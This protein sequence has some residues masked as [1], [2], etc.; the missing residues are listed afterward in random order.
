MS[1]HLT[2][3]SPQLQ[4]GSPELP[5]AEM[6][7]RDDSQ[8]AD[9][10]Q[11][12]EEMEVDSKAARLTNTTQ[13]CIFYDPGRVVLAF[14]RHKGACQQKISLKNLYVIA[15]V[16]GKTERNNPVC[17]NVGGQNVRKEKIEEG[18]WDPDVEEVKDRELQRSASPEFEPAA[19]PQGPEANVDCPICQ[20][21]FP[22][23]EIEIHAA[24][25]DGEVAVVD[26][27]RP[28]VNSFQSE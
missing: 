2:W 28:E 12:E 13:N 24:Y 7:L 26:E 9:Q 25:C 19:I 20:G 23:T 17:R 6:I 4:P 8:A 22:V 15:P 10:Q 14:V 11:V 5:K 1:V 16:Y 21:S 18:R 27:R 3:I